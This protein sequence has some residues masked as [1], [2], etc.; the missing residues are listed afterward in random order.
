MAFIHVVAAEVFVAECAQ[1]PHTADSEQHFL[2][3]TIV[4]IAAIQRAG[5]IAISF[6]IGRQIRVEKING[7][8]ESAHTFGII[9]PGAQLD[10]AIFQRHF[11]TCR[12]L[13]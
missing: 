11:H 10:P 2:A 6:V 4:W 3:Q 7:H 12:L 9:A 13:L 5:Q 8:I 1:H